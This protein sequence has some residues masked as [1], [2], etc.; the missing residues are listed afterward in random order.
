M[1]AVGKLVYSRRL[2][3]A[4]RQAGA[5]LRRFRKGHCDPI[6]AVA[7]GID[8]D[9]I[10]AVENACNNP[11]SILYGNPGTGKTRTVQRIVKSFDNAGMKGLV[12]T[13]TGKAAKRSNEVLL[14]DGAS[15]HNMP[16]CQTTFRGLGWKNGSFTFN[17]ENILPYDY[18]VLEESSM[19]GI[20]DFTNVMLAIDPEKTR[21]VM[22]GDPYQL[23][24]VSPGNVL[25]DC[26]LSG[27]LP[28]VGLT[29]IRRQG[30][31]SGIVYNANRIL[32]GKM[33]LPVNE[34]TGERFTDFYFIA[35]KNESETVE[36]IINWNCGSIERDRGYDSLMEI[37]TLS[38]GHKGLSGTVELNNRIRARI[39]PSG[40][41]GFRGFRVGDKVINRRNN[42]NLDIVNGD[43][44]KVLSVAQYGMEVDFGLGRPV[45]IDKDIGD[46]IQL[47]Y[48]YSVHGSQGSEYKCVLMPFHMTHY[49]MLFQNLAYTGV[50]RARL[51]VM[52]V[53]DTAAY[54]R[55]IEETVTDKRQTG[56]RY[57]I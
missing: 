16:K 6:P 9:Q 33:P 40:K 39:N 45:V 44:G 21:V 18:V 32:H 43:V 50:T 29:K 11:I 19:L 57:W 22:V 15:Y 30:P 53:G 27:K 42:Y 51:L 56:L 5:L 13:P 35:T 48:A 10:F 38:P 54:K 7:D 52:C 34:E 46:S 36:R 1:V 26:I 28:K 2:Y 14:E 41:E 31:N 12:L 17:H 49:K 37:Q 25:Y 3:V 47:A 23:P 55:A 4:E 24:S 8:G 20:E